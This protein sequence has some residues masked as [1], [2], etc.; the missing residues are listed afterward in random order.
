MSVIF[1]HFMIERNLKIAMI[2]ILGLRERFDLNSYVAINHE[3]ELKFPCEISFLTSENSFSF[4]NSSNM[5]HQIFFFS[6]KHCDYYNCMVSF[7]HELIKKHSIFLVQT[8]SRYII[9][10]KVSRIMGNPLAR[11]KDQKKTN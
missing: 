6:K 10:A 3:R 9:G 5:I 4:M 1:Y 2:T 7:Y 11:L 8:S